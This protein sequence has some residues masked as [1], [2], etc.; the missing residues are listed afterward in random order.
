[1]LLKN[2]H[3]L[4]YKGYSCAF[5]ILFYKQHINFNRSKNG[6]SGTLAQGFK[7]DGHFQLS[8][9]IHG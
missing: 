7:P 5:I 3:G 8:L 9:V 1:M 4:S 6:T 2:N